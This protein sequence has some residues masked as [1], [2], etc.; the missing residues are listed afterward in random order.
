MSMVRWWN[1]IDGGKTGV[2]VGKL[3]PVQLR[4]PQISNGLVRDRTR[5]STVRGRR[6]TA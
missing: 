3:V 2:L 6:M 4:R 5:V 1:D